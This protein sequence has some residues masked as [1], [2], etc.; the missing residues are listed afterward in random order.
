MRTFDPQKAGLSFQRCASPDLKIFIF[1]K[2]YYA[3]FAYLYGLGVDTKN[4]LTTIYGK[5]NIL[6]DSFGKLSR[7]LTPG[8]E[9]P[10]ADK[11]W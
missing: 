4:T 3:R 1:Q 9:L 10:A 8:I 11:V 7:Q 2:Y 6:S 5:C